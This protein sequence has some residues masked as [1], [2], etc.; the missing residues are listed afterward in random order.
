MSWLAKLRTKGLDVVPANFIPT[1]GQGGTARIA[2]GF[3]PGTRFNFGRAIHGGLDSNVVMSAVQWIMRAFP[4]AEPVV[5]RKVGRKR[6]WERAEE[7]DLE[8]LLRSPNP[9]YDGA[10]LEQATVLSYVM[11]GNAY[12]IKR[13]N[14]F[15]MVV[16]YWYVPHWMMTPRWNPGSGRFIEWYDYE[17]GEG[18]PEQLAPSDVVHFRFGLNPRNTRC[19]WSQ[20]KTLVREIYTDEEAANFSAMIL[21]NMGVPGLVISPKTADAGPADG[22]VEEVKRY[23]ETSHTGDRR[24]KPLVM[25]APTDVVQFG[26]DP[27][28]LDLSRM[29][30]VSEERVAAA[31]GLPA[32]IIG[33]GTG[34]QSTKVGATMREMRRM[35]WVQCVIPMQLAMGRQLTTQT[36]PDF[37]PLTHRWRVR[38]DTSSVSAFQE[39][40]TEKATRLKTLVGAGIMRV[41][42][43][44][45]AAGLEVDESQRVYLRPSGVVAVEEGDIGI[46]AD[47]NAVAA[48]DAGDAGDGQGGTA[49][50]PGSLE[51]IMAEAAT[52]IAQRREAVSNGNG[53]NS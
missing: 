3:L 25:S 32:A 15:G 47:P 38:F 42:Q 28:R 53:A 17:P 5:E 37:E 45:E 34:L 6:P 4:E 33:F 31:V 35:A 49:P 21:R 7:H 19:G 51:A 13:R 39:E 44:Q 43:A 20:I 36:V 46:P 8:L 48:G 2:D 27:N 12:W 24:G 23:L 30:D 29:R 26:F 11:D 9:G 18:S 41:D 52:A 10:I 16:E 22:D 14:D 50:A 1:D 40:E